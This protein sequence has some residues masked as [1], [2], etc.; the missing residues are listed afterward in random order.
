MG[1]RIELGSDLKVHAGEFDRGSGCAA[2]SRVVISASLTALCTQKL[3][4]GAARFPYAIGTQLIIAQR[5][6]TVRIRLEAVDG[7]SSAAV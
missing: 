4:V 5:G 2:S 7:K 3:I 1:G 6:M